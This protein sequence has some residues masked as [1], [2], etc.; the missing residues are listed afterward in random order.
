M[1]HMPVLS[2]NDTNP[3]NNYANEHY[4][5]AYIQRESLRENPVNVI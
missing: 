1:T 5:H 3:Y 4:A 2:K